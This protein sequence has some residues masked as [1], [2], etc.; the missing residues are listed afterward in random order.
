MGFETGLRA[1]L[2]DAI[3]ARDAVADRVA[4]SKAAVERVG[5]QAFEAARR[6]NQVREQ[7]GERA[8]DRIAAL[9][10]GGDAAV[11]DRDRFAKA[12]AE[13]T[14][15]ACKA[16]RTLC[17]AALAE[18]EFDLSL[19][20]RRVAGAVD[21][22]LATA[23]QQLLAQAERARREFLSAASVLR[24]LRLGVS[25]SLR[26]RIDQ[27]TVHPTNFDSLAPSWAAAREAL[28]TDENAALPDA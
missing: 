17:Q 8:S 25:D 2:K 9:V 20:E 21:A 15:T 11:L 19:K 23:A 18:A 10:A 26:Q 7:A 6:L 24:H 28:L 13:E 22:V 3:A 5:D 16:A 4:A 14:I 12:E 27:V 1:S